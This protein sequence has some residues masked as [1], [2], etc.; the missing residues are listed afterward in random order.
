V[1]GISLELGAWFL[2]LRAKASLKNQAGILVDTIHFLTT[3]IPPH[4]MAFSFIARGGD[5]WR[6]RVF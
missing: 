5:F 2:E 4:E 6:G 3:F 1:L